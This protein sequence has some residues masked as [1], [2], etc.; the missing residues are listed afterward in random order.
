MIVVAEY[1]NNMTVL[2][3]L[4]YFSATGHSPVFTLIIKAALHLCGH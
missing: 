1:F 3:L 4:N 2:Q